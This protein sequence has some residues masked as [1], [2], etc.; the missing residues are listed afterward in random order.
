MMIPP[1]GEQDTA[2]IQRREIQRIIAPPWRSLIGS[3]SS[4]EKITAVY[5]PILI[6]PEQGSPS[7]FSSWVSTSGA[8]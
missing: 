3:Y 2:D 5:G 7:N 4:C 1:V 6:L 8:G